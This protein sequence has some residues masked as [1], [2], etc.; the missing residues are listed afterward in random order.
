M[1]EI[2]D[3]LLD[4]DFD[5]IKEF[6]NPMPSWWI[7]LFYLS[8]IWAFVYIFYYHIF[9]IGALSK[10]EYMKEIDPTWTDPN[11]PQIPLFVIYQAPYQSNQ[12][13]MTPR[14]Q[15]IK[16][17][18]SLIGSAS[19]DEVIDVQ[20]LTETADIE[21]GRAQFQKNCTT[22]HGNEGQGL[23]GPNLADD[24]WIHGQGDINNIYRVVKYGV[25][26]KGMIAWNK[27]LKA[28][29]LLQVS[30]YILTLHGTNPPNPKPPQGNK[31]GN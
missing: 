20:P 21:K 30:S 1:Q 3:E 27:T 22:C 28:D 8:I 13:D 31:I 11:P 26:A 5:G 10:S 19:A 2:R 23:I 6:D 29:E 15:L 4:H 14:L 9:Q 16:A 17:G 7:Y 18:K 24:Y 25:P 12:V